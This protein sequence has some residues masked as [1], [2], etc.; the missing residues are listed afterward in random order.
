MKLWLE[1]FYGNQRVETKI[2]RNVVLGKGARFH[3]FC[4]G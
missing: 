1:S 2:K 4:T 3:L